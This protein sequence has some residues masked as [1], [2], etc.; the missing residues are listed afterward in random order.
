MISAKAA[1]ESWQLGTPGMRGWF[2]GT[3]QS[4]PFL[5]SLR[6][7]GRTKAGQ[8][9]G[10]MQGASGTTHDWLAVI[11]SLGLDQLTLSRLAGGL[12]QSVLAAKGVDGTMSGLLARH[13]HGTKS[14]AHAGGTIKLS[15]LKPQKDY[16]QQTC[17]PGIDTAGRKSRAGGTGNE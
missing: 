3:L 16:C 5:F 6:A 17:K 11:N 1:A 10:F 14:G 2:T 4:I 12:L 9:V 13:E 7:E 15:D 8:G